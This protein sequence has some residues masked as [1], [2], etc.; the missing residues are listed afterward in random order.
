MR[1]IVVLGA[2]YAGL[3]TV[4]RIARQTYREE[5]ELVLVSTYDEFVERPRLHQ[6]ATGQDRP[7]LPLSD[8]LGTDVHLRVGRADRI[9]ADAHSLAFTLRPRRRRHT[10]PS[11]VPLQDRS[12]A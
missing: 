11:V 10:T 5:V 8:F 2:G 6:L 12:A 3:P 1:R 4:N 9:D 7:H